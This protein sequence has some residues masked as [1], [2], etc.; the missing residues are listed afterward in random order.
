MLRYQIDL[1]GRYRGS[2]PKAKVSAEN[3]I[4]IKS[5]RKRYEQENGTLQGRTIRMGSECRKRKSQAADDVFM[6]LSPTVVERYPP[7]R[8]PDR[9]T[10]EPAAAAT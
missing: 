3:I 2:I 4:Q 7:S 8:R 10:A 6:A 1:I 9:V 5:E